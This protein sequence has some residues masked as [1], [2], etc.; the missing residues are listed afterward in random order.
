VVRYCCD[1]CKEEIGCCSDTNRLED[2]NI[3]TSLF[4]TVDR[5]GTGF[6]K[7]YKLL[8]CENCLNKLESFLSSK[9]NPCDDSDSVPGEFEW[10]GQSYRRKVNVLTELPT[11]PAPTM[12]RETFCGNKE[13]K[14]K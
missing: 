10:D 4:K 12:I 9:R 14:S 6:N 5:D 2:F 1:K 8:L 7:T 3:K 13:I 11:S